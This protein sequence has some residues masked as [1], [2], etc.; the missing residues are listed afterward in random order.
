MGTTACIHTYQQAIITVVLVKI[1]RKENML[2]KE[3]DLVDFSSFFNVTAGKEVPFFVAS[4]CNTCK[5]SSRRPF[6][7][8]HLGDSGT[9]LCKWVEPK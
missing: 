8:N 6:N 9:I 5:A 4:V 1:I 2:N 3:A 7:S